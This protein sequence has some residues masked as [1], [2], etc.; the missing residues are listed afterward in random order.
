MTASTMP[1]AIDGL[2]A[3]VRASDDLADLVAAGAIFDGPPRTDMPQ[4]FVS[5]GWG[6]ADEDPSVEATDTDGGLEANREDYSIVG[7]VYVWSGD[8]DFA[9]LRARCFAR[10]DA[11]N[12]AILADPSLGGAVMRARLSANVLGQ[13]PIQAGAAAAVRFTVTCAA[14]TR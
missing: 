3:A 12:A 11:V 6:G 2:L 10:L 13:A 9:P 8:S 7:L 1:A 14:F 5:I 4:E